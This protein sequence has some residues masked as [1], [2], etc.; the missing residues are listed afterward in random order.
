MA[1]QRSDSRQRLNSPRAELAIVKQPVGNALDRI[2]AKEQKR[3][4][5][6]VPK[7]QLGRKPVTAR[8]EERIRELRGKGMGKLKIARELS[9]GVSTVQRV[10]AG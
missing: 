8:T 1:S 3:Q 10:L 7:T 9:C 5:R 6:G 4:S 2:P